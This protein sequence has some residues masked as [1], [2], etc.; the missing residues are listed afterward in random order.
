MCKIYFTF[1]VGLK[2]FVNTMKYG[3]AY[4]QL[5]FSKIFQYCFLWDKVQ[6]YCTSLQNKS[7][8][9]IWRM[10]LACCISIATDTHSP[11]AMIIVVVYVRI[12]HRNIRLT[13]SFWLKIR[14]F[15]SYT[16]RLRIHVVTLNLCFHSALTTYAFFCCMNLRCWVF[17]YRILERMLGS[18]FSKGQNVPLN[19]S[20]RRYNNNFYQKIQ[21][22]ITQWRGCLTAHLAV[23]KKR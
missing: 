23:S 19:F 14:E 6:K 5:L 2:L 21:E 10:R 3:S 11:Y 18:H 4:I 13:L 9:M 1:W 15:L 8:D 20:R 22:I 17:G 12:P 16:I 7:D